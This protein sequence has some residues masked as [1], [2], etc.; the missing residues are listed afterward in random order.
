MNARR[1]VT[2]TNRSL[3]ATGHAHLAGRLRRLV[4]LTPPLV[5][6]LLICWLLASLSLLPSPALAQSDGL[7]IQP[8]DRT[9]LTQLPR[10]VATS[11][12]RVTNRSG[13][14]A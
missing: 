7:V 12:I 1:A 9:L 10:D 5:Y 3:H 8:G 2:K 4:Q 14:P 13:T 6:R 11:V